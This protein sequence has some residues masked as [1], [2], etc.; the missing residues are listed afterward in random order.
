MRKAKKL[1]CHSAGQLKV[2]Q[3]IET[4]ISLLHEQIVD[5]D[6]QIAAFLAEDQT[7]AAIHPLVPGTGLPS[8]PRCSATFPR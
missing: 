1:H 2:T 8:W 6:R 5:L 3:T 4:M 7:L